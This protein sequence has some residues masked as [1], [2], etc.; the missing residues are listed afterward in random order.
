MGDIIEVRRSD[1][2]RCHDIRVHTKFHTDWFRHQKVDGG[3]HRHTD[4]MVISLANFHF[5]KIR[6]AGKIKKEM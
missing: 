4:I 1:G 2:V 6:K 5:F 3:I